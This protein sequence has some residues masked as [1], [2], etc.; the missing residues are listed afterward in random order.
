MAVAKAT[1]QKALAVAIAVVLAVNPAEM[2]AAKK[3]PHKPLVEMGNARAANRKAIAAAIAVVPA[4]SPAITTNAPAPNTIALRESLAA[5]AP[6]P[7]NAA[8]TTAVALAGSI[9]PPVQAAKLVKTETVSPPL[10]KHPTNA[11]PKATA[12]VAAEKR[13][14]VNSSI[15]AA[16]SSL[17]MTAPQKA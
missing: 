14:I 7:N 8:K 16:P 15:T 9:S 1:N 2:E 13:W 3:T 17:V 12:S 5:T 6:P 10:A 4:D 11:P